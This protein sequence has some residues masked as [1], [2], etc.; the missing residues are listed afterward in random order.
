VLVAVSFP[1][2]GVSASPDL[3]DI[4]MGQGYG[5]LRHLAGNPV[6]DGGDHQELLALVFFAKHQRD[7]GTAQHETG[8]R[9]GFPRLRT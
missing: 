2:Q 1:Q 5:Q 8:V 3:C 4:D 7:A 6:F 9:E